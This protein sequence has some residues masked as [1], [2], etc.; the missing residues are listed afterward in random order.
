[1]ELL[2]EIERE[3]IVLPAI[4]RD[5]VWSPEQTARLLDSVI[6]GY[7]LGIVLLWETYND[8]SFRSFDRDFRS[9]TVHDFHGNRRHRRLKLVLDGQQ[10]LQSLYVALRG[11]RDG[12]PV[13][14]NILS[15]R[16]A[17]ET[18]EQRYSFEL[19]GTREAAQ[20]NRDTKRARKAEDTD[21]APDWWVATA[22]LFEMGPNE[23]RDFVRETGRAL[24]LSD[25]E[26]LVL[27]LNVSAFHERL[28]ADQNILQASTI[29]ANL[30]P[31][32]P[33]R[34][35]YSDVLEI[36]V[37]VNR[38]GTALWRSDLIFSLL[39]LNW[40]ESAEELPE[41]LVSINQG[42]SFDLDTDFVIRC[43][44][45]VSGLGGKLD[46]DL[47]RKQ[48]N[49]ALLQAN[50]GSCCEAIRATVDFVKTECKVESSDLLG[51]SNTLV[52]FVY[53][54]FNLPRHEI[55]N[56]ETDRLRTAVYLLGLGKPFS[57]YSE[58]RIGAYV[59][60][61]LAPLVE[62]DDHSFPL[63]DTLDWV[64]Y[65]EGVESLRDLARKN[66]DLT[67]H[68]IQGLSGAK[69]QYERNSPE[70]DHI[71]PRS[72]LRKKDFNE[73]EIN[74]PA[75]FWILARGKNRNKSNRPPKKYFEDVSDSQLKRALVDRDLLVYSRY[76]AFL[77]KRREAMLK[78]LEK[79]VG[80]SDADF[81]EEDDEEE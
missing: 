64:V 32:S 37:R 67:L 9:G 28:T 66:T 75:N 8:I 27:A 2:N 31:E 51:N 14:F 38:E 39:K 1:M 71:F 44:F 35:T 73:D 52:P 23:R 78:Q 36:F 3:D 58:S 45:A 56:A 59:R 17:D 22:E 43:L 4:Q 20:R 46:L 48:S 26:E 55:P 30:A 69:V 16:D 62:Q 18:A 7:P 80:L 40:T 41:F 63:E 81:E 53:W 47:L 79:K 11:Q 42:N 10:R 24:T 25:D 68:L 76:K 34:K 19:M 74:D 70:L 50:F 5:F 61:D 54:L 72:T 12:Q 57:R 15:G 13:H 29:D 6:R 33:D 49:V 21:D 65:W 60:Q 77:R